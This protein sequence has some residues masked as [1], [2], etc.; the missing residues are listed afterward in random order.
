MKKWIK[1]IV[2]IGLIAL[3]ILTFVSRTVYNSNLTQVTAISPIRAFIPLEHKT[4]GSLF[5][6]NEVEVIADTQWIID[7]VL[8]EDGD[9][10]SRRDLL[11]TLDTFDLDMQI[12]Q[13]ELTLLQLENSFEIHVDS[14][15]QY[16]NSRRDRQ[17]WENM[18]DELTAQISII[19]T[20]LDRLH[21]I[22]PASINIYAETDGFV[23]G[24]SVK[25]GDVI[26]RGAQVLTLIPNNDP[27]LLKFNLPPRDG[28]AFNK[29]ANIYAS[30][31]VVVTTGDNREIFEQLTVTGRITSFSLRDGQWECIVI[32]N[33]YEGQAVIDQEVL[34]TAEQQGERHELVVP[35][36]S[37]FSGIGGQKVVYIINTRSGLFGE[38][39]Y[40]TEASI[41]VIFDNGT[42]ASI[43]GGGILQETL[44]AAR[45]SG[46]INSGDVVW[47]R[48]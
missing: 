15:R 21:D 35:M 22:Y 6:E 5:F 41:E 17:I 7:E 37:I 19:Q 24:L 3:A 26:W 28:E 40:L 34:V 18:H 9:H 42:H 23:S 48:E 1:I 11:L 2:V 38:E 46:R 8:V 44:L 12:M 27:P 13:L 47:V 30:M 32:L 43:T 16:Q 10:I 36:E 14:R 33:S 4:I 39:S 29:S 20:Q 31:G 45:P 25:P